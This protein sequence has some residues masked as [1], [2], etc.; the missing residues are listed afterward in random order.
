VCNK[1]FALLSLKEA[2]L[3]LKCDPAKAVELR[4]QFPSVTAAYHM[5]KRL[6][7][8]VMLDGAVPDELLRG[9]VDDS[10]ALVVDTLTK[11]QKLTIKG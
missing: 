10:Y 2:R 4:E 7:N 5:H 1:I 11:A 3:N 9:W 6:W 8:T